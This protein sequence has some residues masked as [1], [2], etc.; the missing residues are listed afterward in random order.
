VAGKFYDVSLSADELLVGTEHE[1]D[2]IQGVS[3]L[4]FGDE[5]M[6][7]IAD[8]LPGFDWAKK[9]AKRLR[10]IDPDVPAASGRFLAP[11][12]LKVVE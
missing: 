10:E 5:H 6:P 7:D 8:I 12:I 3:A 1:T 4:V 11:T 9:V 2:G